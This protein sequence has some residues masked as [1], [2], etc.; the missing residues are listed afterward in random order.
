MMT[1]ALLYKEEGFAKGITEKKRETL[2]KKRSE[3]K[4]LTGRGR[5]S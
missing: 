5:G 1:K 4:E 2:Y 3:R